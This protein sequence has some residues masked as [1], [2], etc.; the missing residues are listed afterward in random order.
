[1]KE[2]KKVSQELPS[3]SVAA[4]GETFDFSTSSFSL[5]LYFYFFPYMYLIL[6][7]LSQQCDLLLWWD[8]LRSR[9]EKGCGCDFYGDFSKVFDIVSQSILERLAAH[10]L[11]RSMV[12][13]VKIWLDDQAPR[14]TVTGAHS[15]WCL[16]TSCIPR[17]QCWGQ[18]CF[19]FLSVIWMRG[20]SVPSVCSQITL[21]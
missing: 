12:C 15:T 19:M 17:A 16:L 13:G 8:D 5:A 1:M 20:L 10:G 3:L 11:D 18:F 7:L 2:T 4:S 6:S 21:S 14:V 9:W